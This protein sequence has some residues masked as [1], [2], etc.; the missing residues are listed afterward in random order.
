[1]NKP[2]DVVKFLNL[3]KCVLS[4]LSFFLL[5][6]F[7]SCD[8]GVASN[9]FKLSGK[10]ENVTS[11][12]FYA[13][14]ESD[15][16]KVDTIKVDEDGEFSFRS[17]IDTLTIISLYFNQNTQVAYVIVDKG[18]NVKLKGDVMFPDLLKV[19][20]GEINDDITA[21]REQNEL[22]LKQRGEILNNIKAAS[23]KDSLI[24]KNM[25]QLKNLNFELSNV[26]A[27]YV[28]ANPSKIASTILVYTFFKDEAFIPRLD[29]NLSL[30]RGKAAIFPLAGEL[31]AFSEKVKATQVGSTAPNIYLQNLKNKYLNLYDYRGKYLFLLFESTIC[32][33]CAVEQE[34]AVQVYKKLKE[35]KKNIDFLSI[36]IETELRP[37]S[38]N[39]SD[40]IKW[41]MLPDTGGWGAKSL[42]TYNIRELP[43]NIL[44]SPT[45][46]ILERDLPVNELEQK[47]NEYLA[48]ENK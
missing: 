18:W 34:Q 2:D 30:L 16:P 23:N 29:E 28:K 11:G 15:Q 26:A 36:V 32:D 22:L 40:T 20:G 45:G 3:K 7:V 48:K 25:G 43:Y 17:D 5:L 14:H 1:M 19:T 9:E 10:L 46:L 31:K 24:A 21:F 4:F 27:D 8:G 37:L 42:D 38:K 47:L 12:Y 33:V 13:V 41:Q 35:Q 6:G 44:I 39:I